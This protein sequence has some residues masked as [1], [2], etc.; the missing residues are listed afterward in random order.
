MDYGEKI[1]ELSVNTVA[2]ISCRSRLTK[3]WAVSPRGGEGKLGW[4]RPSEV[5]R[6][7]Y[8]DTNL[9]FNPDSF[10]VTTKGNVTRLPPHPYF[11]SPP[12][13]HLL[14]LWSVYFCSWWKQQCW[15]KATNLYLFTVICRCYT[16]MSQV[17][18]TLFP[19]FYPIFTIIIVVFIMF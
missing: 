6:C 15:L 17:S 16:D 11:L 18:I 19:S 14:T 5:T 1:K 10:P 13:Q 7:W 12:Y 3:V 9:Y 8:Q 2:F 4:R